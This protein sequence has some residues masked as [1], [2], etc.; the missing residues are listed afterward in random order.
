MAVT[1]AGG[2]APDTVLQVGEVY[3]VTLGRSTMEFLRA[4]LFN[5]SADST[6]EVFQREAVTL[7]E[8]IASTALNVY[9]ASPAPAGLS[10]PSTVIDVKVGKAPKGAR[11]GELVT[12][13]E[14]LSSYSLIA[15]VARIGQAQL[16]TTAA[17][18][19]RQEIAT[20]QVAAQG[21]PF[22][23]LFDSLKQFWIALVVLAVLAVVV[24]VLARRR[25]AGT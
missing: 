19:Q 14:R 6:L 11:L 17:P 8:G 21:S 18:K 7:W 2:I 16:S 1:Y 12:A 24:L 3:R 22:S 23:G 10:G 20:A 13:L 25:A 5:P 4:A 9:P 15:A